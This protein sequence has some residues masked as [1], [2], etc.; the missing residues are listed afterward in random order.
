MKKIFKNIFSAAALVAGLSMMASC[1]PE[2]YDGLD[3][4]GIP[5]A[6]DLDVEIVLDQEINQY[7]LLLKNPGMYPIWRVY[8]SPTKSTLSTVNG[9]TGIIAAAGTYTVEVQ[10]G[11]RNGVCEGVKTLQFT[12]DN[13]QVDFSR[14][15]NR[16]T[17]GESKT[18]VF[19]V[20]KQGHLGC[21]EPGTDG[22]NWWSAGPHEK[23]P[24]GIADNSFIFVANGSD[25]GGDYTFDPGAAGTCYFNTG[26]NNALP[27][28]NSNP[29]DGND[30]TAPAEV[31]NTTFSFSVEG[32]DIFLSFPAGTLVGYVS[33]NGQFENPK[34]KL[35][36][37][38][39]DSL[40]LTYIGDGIN[41]HYAFTIP[42]EPE[43]SGF[44]YDS[45][46]NMWKDCTITPEFYYADPNWSQLPD[47][48]Y[49]MSGN[50][51]MTLNLPTANTSQ[52][53]TQ[54]KLHTNLSSNTA[55]N[56]DFSVVLNVSKDLK[57]ATVKLT[58]DGDDNNFFFADQV[59]LKADQNYVF[60]KS[61]MPGIDAPALMLVLDF[62]GCQENTDVQI[63]NVVFKN[64]ADDDGTVLPTEP[65]T[66][67]VEWRE[68]DNIWKPEAMDKFTYYYAPGWA[69]IANP[70]CEDNGDGSYTWLFPEAT[71]D[72]W[73]A[74][75][76]IPSTTNTEAEKKYDFRVIIESDQEFMGA[77]I[78]FV[79][80]G[81]GDNDNI[82][83]MADRMQVQEGENVYEFVG[84]TC[85]EAIQGL[86]YAGDFGGCPANTTITIKSILIQEHIGE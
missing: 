57:G 13:S 50:Q 48:E 68:A 2:K 70:E 3:P 66:P 72:Q 37:L 12:F 11:N 21:G 65:D 18:W 28:S 5:V 32:A 52:W 6:S 41:W 69:Q 10:A 8:T 19:D 55:T 36:G 61:D 17:G 1:S 35:N 23:D 78:K 46:Y 40:D 43:F 49:T 83:F 74:Q 77:T 64:H 60:Y 30:Y 9:Q 86:H 33:S 16:I 62:G 22:T 53:Q 42:G 31:Q 15:V 27:Y 26:V 20:E 85:S 24:F 63:M 79:K 14:Y 76:G 39:N 29:N 34:F 82:F 84:K 56:Y 45:P 81:G 38:T 54:V 44:K 58:Q 7:T 47:P 80:P 59:D 71:S 4:N 67:T 73:Q 25:D 75:V 51:Q